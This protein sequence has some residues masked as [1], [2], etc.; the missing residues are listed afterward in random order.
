MNQMVMPEIDDSRCTLCGACIH[1]C[2]HGALYLAEGR[3]A[4]HQALCS[5]CGDCEGICPHGAIALPYEI[6]LRPRQN[7]LEVHQ[8]GTP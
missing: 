6:I 3:I 7:S 5:Y 1:R 8:D 4:L 2:P